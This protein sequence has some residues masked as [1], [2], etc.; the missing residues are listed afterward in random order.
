MTDSTPPLPMFLADTLLTAPRDAMP[1]LWFK[2]KLCKMTYPRTIP[3]YSYPKSGYDVATKGITLYD[4]QSVEQLS[5]DDTFLVLDAFAIKDYDFYK[6]QHEKLNRARYTHNTQY[7][8]PQKLPTPVTL[9]GSEDSQLYYS[10]TVNV[11]GQENSTSPWPSNVFILTP[12]GKIGWIV[13]FPFDL[14]L[15]E[16]STPSQ[17]SSP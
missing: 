13:A 3:V 4:P 12:T 8:A 6:Q 17:Q 16:A 2:S 14:M 7:Y 1:P 5:S 9:F 11:K 15:A 10:T